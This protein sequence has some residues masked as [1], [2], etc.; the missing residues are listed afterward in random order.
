MNK[1]TVEKT[2]DHCGAFNVVHFTERPAK[3]AKA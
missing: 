2:C 1:G 3:Q